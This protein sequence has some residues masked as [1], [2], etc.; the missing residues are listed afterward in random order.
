MIGGSPHPRF[1]S[2]NLKVL[3]RYLHGGYVGLRLADV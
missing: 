1:G 3:M 2:P